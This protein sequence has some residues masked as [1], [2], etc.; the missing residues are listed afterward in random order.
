LSLACG[1]NTLAYLRRS[2]AGA[3]AGNFPKLHWRHFDVQINPIQQ[4]TGNPAQI[5][6]DFARRTF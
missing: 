5:I 2:F 1:N 4:R 6:L 3:V